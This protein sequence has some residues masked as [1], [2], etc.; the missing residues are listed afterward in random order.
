MS[1]HFLAPRFDA[2]Y[3]ESITQFRLQNH[4]SPVSP[5]ELFMLLRRF[6]NISSH[7]PR[8]AFFYSWLGVAALLAVAQAAD[9]DFRTWSD[10]TGAFK[11]EAKLIKVEGN[12]VYLESKAGK[13]LKIPKDKLSAADQ[14]VLEAQPAAN[15]FQDAEPASPFTP[16]DD[17]PKKPRPGLKGKTNDAGAPAP[18]LKQKAEPKWDNVKQLNSSFGGATE[19]KLTVPE[20]KPDTLTGAKSFA[21]PPGETREN[22]ESF[23]ISKPGKKLMACYTNWS[24][25]YTRLGLLDMTNGKGNGTA[26]I[27]G[28]YKLVAINDAGDEA[29]MCADDHRENKGMLEVW[30][31]GK[32]GIE[33][34]RGWKM[35]RDDKDWNSEAS[36]GRY[37][38]D[39]RAITKANHGRAVIWDLS[40][41]QP[42]AA[43]DDD[44]RL[45]AVTLSPDRS[46][47]AMAGNNSV[48]ILDTKTLE[49]IATKEVSMPMSA[50]AF[51]PD[52]KKLAIGGITQL[53]ILD[54]AT[55]ES[56]WQ[57]KRRGAF[58]HSSEVLWTDN[59]FLLIGKNTLLDVETGK[60]LW[61]YTGADKMD[62][63]G[64]YVWCYVTEFRNKGM[65]PLKLPHEAAKTAAKTFTP[66]PVEYLLQAGDTLSVDVSAL[67]DQQK[68]LAAEEGI[69]KQML[70]IGYKYNQQAPTK[71]IAMTETGQTQKLAYRPFGAFRG[72]ILQDRA[73]PAIQEFDF[74]PTYCV[75]KIVRDDKVL[76][77]IRGGGYAPGG[78]IT[79]NQ[80]ETIADRVNKAAQPDFT[81]YA[82]PPL[83]KQIEKPGQKFTAGSSRITSNGVK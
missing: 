54:T 80:G 75:L 40:T 11:V 7:M 42:L 58:G 27:A 81:I 72:P 14:K 23:A 45:D 83:P 43:T 51:S 50:L 37:I 28:R 8:R 55:G 22:F 48:K 62:Y 64:G 46:W 10:T 34:V 60:P 13:A 20:L 76:W 79:L 38:D 65:V 47:L 4:V 19:W 18:E 78:F 36:W 5:R 56:L 82:N 21:I 35:Q 53:E 66:P 32:T 16:G 39:K 41:G 2:D 6:A 3:N 59:N 24:Q 33:R 63:L 71:I 74:T 26:A 29:I 44:T 25:E 49:V 17:T 70:K 31:L 57:A 12:D 61:E 69:L 68:M 9:E 67:G 77:Q 1:E 15:P 30:K 73:G 52:G